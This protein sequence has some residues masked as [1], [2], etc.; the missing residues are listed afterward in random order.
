MRKF[1]YSIVIFFFLFTDSVFAQNIRENLGQ[2][3]NA[4]YGT[5]VKKNPI[6]VASSIIRGGLGLMGILLIIYCVYGGVL[7]MT[8]GGESAKVDKAKDSIKSAI[9]GL[10]IIVSVYAISIFVV[11]ALV[12]ATGATG[13]TSANTATPPKP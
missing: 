3:G 11:D 5:A 8:A 9:I 6:E 12:D 4:A 7:W 13:N 10:I 1:F 2:F